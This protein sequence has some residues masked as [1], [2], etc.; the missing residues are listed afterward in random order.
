MAQTKN[1]A[2]CAT[3]FACGRNDAECWCAALP[4]LP[5]TDLDGRQDCYCPSCLAS[6]IAARRDAAPPSEADQD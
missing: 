1:C 3:P 6:I 5:V 4:A 2:R